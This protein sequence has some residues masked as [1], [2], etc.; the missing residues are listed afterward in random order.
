MARPLDVPSYHEPSLE[1]NH[2]DAYELMDPSILHPKR[3]L[4]WQQTKLK[5]ENEVRI[6]IVVIT[7]LVI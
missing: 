3:K 6:V 4:L 7:G 2:G 5:I 1:E